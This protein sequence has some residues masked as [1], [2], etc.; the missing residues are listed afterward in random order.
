MRRR[1]SIP[2]TLLKPPAKWEPIFE[3][4]YKLSLDAEVILFGN[5]DNRFYATHWSKVGVPAK[6]E[7]SLT[8]EEAAQIAE[9]MYITGA[10]E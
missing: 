7:Y 4:S 1:E 9:T 8:F 6:T 10:W 5:F 2:C 3:N